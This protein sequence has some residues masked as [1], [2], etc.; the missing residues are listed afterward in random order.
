M[1]VLYS[2][3]SELCANDERQCHPA[4]RNKYYGYFK[5]SSCM[6]FVE[7]KRSI[8]CTIIFVPKVR[9]TQFGIGLQPQLRPENHTS[10]RLGWPTLANERT[11]LSSD[12]VYWILEGPD[13]PIGHKSESTYLLIIIAKTSSVDNH[14]CPPKREHVPSQVQISHRPT[15]TT[16]NGM[17]RLCFPGL[18]IV[19]HPLMCF[20]L[21]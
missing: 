6:I 17:Q 5:L 10:S 13:I 4:L 8:E 12:Y 15:W 18:W 9:L 21:R 3:P 14:R 7:P 19:L 20:V 2:V 11:V 16:G 1:I